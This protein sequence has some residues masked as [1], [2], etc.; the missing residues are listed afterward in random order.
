MLP[1]F[2]PLVPARISLSCLSLHPKFV[3]YSLSTM[4][5][6]SDITLPLFDECWRVPIRPYD[7]YRPVLPVPPPQLYPSTHLSATLALDACLNYNHVP[8]EL[9][10]LIKGYL[11]KPIGND[12]R[13]A[14]RVW[15]LNGWN[16][17]PVNQK[18][19]EMEY[20]HISH[21]DTSH[22]TDMSSLFRNAEMFNLPLSGWDTSSVTIMDNMFNEARLFNQPGIIGTLVMLDEWLICLV[23][24]VSSIK[25]FVIG[26]FK[27]SQI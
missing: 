18:N 25:I 4:V 10:L 22:V 26:R 21:W 3:R 23:V 16:F 11:Y 17:S 1:L 6:E 24:Q 15:P 12:I 2:R 14:M 7:V 13:T 5:N 8:V 19:T 27:M 9:R 20:G